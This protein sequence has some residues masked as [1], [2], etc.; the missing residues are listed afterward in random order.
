MRK[1]ATNPFK[2]VVIKKL[3]TGNY[4]QRFLTHLE[5][6]SLL[7]SCKR[8]K[9][10]FLHFFVKLLLLTGAQKS[11]LRPAKWTCIDLQ[12]GELFVAINKGGRSRTVVF[13]T[14]ALAVLEQV[15]LWSEALGLPIT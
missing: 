10:P 1:K 15:K 14:K 5:I 4:M 13:S 9:H 12:K 2:V 6:K 3:P 11:E 7:N 8:S